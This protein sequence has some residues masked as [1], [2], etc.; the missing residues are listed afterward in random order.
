MDF[1][2][3]GVHRAPALLP[4]SVP[5]ASWTRRPSSS[6]TRSSSPKAVSWGD[7]RGVGE[8]EGGWI[9]IPARA[10]AGGGFTGSRLPPLADASTYAHFLFDAFDADRSGALCFQVSVPAPLP[11]PASRPAKPCRRGAPGAAAGCKRAQRRDSSD[12]PPRPRAVGD[13]SSA[14]PKF[15]DS[16]TARACAGRVPGTAAGVVGGGA[17]AGFTVVIKN[18]YERE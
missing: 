14:Q 13:K 7:P 10:G 4:R 18:S 3:A 8:S 1:G 17:G 9:P 6:S 16:S 11:R 2:R 12:L 5:A 15:S